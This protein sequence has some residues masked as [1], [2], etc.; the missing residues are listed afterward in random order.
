MLRQVGRT[1]QK[2][3]S[4]LFLPEQPDQLVLPDPQVAQDQLAPLAQQVLVDLLVLMVATEVTVLPDLL[5]VKD[6]L[7]LLARPDHLDLRDL[8]DHRV[9][10]VVLHSSTT[11]AQLQQTATPVQVR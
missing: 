6:L 4:F 2:Y 11:L 7:V 9:P 10:L 5:V 1:L 8:L 3:L